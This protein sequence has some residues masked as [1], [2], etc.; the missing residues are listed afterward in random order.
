[1]V[2]RWSSMHFSLLSHISADLESFCNNSNSNFRSDVGEST[3]PTVDVDAQKFLEGNPRG[4][5]EIK[6][7]TKRWFLLI[8]RENNTWFWKGSGTGNKF[9][10][11]FFGPFLIKLKIIKD[12][13]HFY[14]ITEENISHIVYQTRDWKGAIHKLHLGQFAG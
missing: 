5:N 4:S 2:I 14:Y 11:L 7:E 1:M 10:Y 13:C 3:P 8:F 12:I 9:W 6:D